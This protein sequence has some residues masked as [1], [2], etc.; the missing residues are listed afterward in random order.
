MR[1]HLVLCQ[2]HSA[3]CAITGR[4]PCQ[5]SI[6]R[7]CLVAVLT[8][9]MGSEPVN[10]VYWH[11]TYITPTMPRSSTRQQSAAVDTCT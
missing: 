1:M 8:W 2:L 10:S 11:T 7:A 4:D 6:K 5:E 3:R 9:S